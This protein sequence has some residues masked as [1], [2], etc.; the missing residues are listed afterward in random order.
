MRGYL[1]SFGANPMA[2]AGLRDLHNAP[3]VMKD[4]FELGRSLFHADSL[5]LRRDSYM[6]LNLGWREACAES[7]FAQG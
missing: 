7:G 3:G 1:M 6:A 5:C 2:F 4:K